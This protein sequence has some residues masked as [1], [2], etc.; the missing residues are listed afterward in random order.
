[1][2]GK[3]ETEPL[4]ERMNNSDSKIMKLIFPIFPVDHI[5]IDY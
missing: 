3:Q 1:M 5:I 2:L 4:R